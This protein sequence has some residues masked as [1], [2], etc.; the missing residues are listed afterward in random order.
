[1]LLPGAGYV[2][3][4][5]AYVSNRWEYSYSMLVAFIL[6]M[7]WKKIF[8][9]SLKKFLAIAGFITLYAGVSI[10]TAKEF[11]SEMEGNVWMA[12]VALARLSLTMHS[13]SGHA[14]YSERILPPPR[15]PRELHPPRTL[16][17]PLQNGSFS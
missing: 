10:W 16:Q 11:A 3:N 5:F 9:L 12:S 8:C 15:P 1:M 7:E 14:R 17:N 2:L 13:E 6:V 4:G